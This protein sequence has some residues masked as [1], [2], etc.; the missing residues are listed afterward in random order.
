MFNISFA[1]ILVFLSLALIILGPEKLP[2]ALNTTLAY[3]R[4]LKTSLHH[5]QH[6]LE[7]ELELAELQQLMHVE[8]N[9]IQQNEQY[10]KA[11]LAQMQ[12][13]IGRLQPSPSAHT[14][15]SNLSYCFMQNAP[16]HIPYRQGYRCTASADRELA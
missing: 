4:K 7:R 15:L 13:E 10:L 5:L 12:D 6:S 2:Q 14:P 11:Q 1:E 3:Y 9:K 8:L 16:Q